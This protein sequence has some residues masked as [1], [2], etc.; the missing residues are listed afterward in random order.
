MLCPIAAFAQYP[1]A[2]GWC[3]DGAQNVITSGLTSSSTV[4]GSFPQCTVTISI[5]GGGLATIYS[6]DSGTPLANPFTANTNGQWQFFALTGA[7]DIALSGAGF[8]T[9]ITY[10]EVNIGFGGG[11][12]GGSVASVSCTGLTPL[13]T[14]A[15]ANPTTNPAISFGLSNAAGNT[16]F[17]NCSG[18][19]G[20]PSYCAITSAMLPSGPATIGGSIASPQVAFGSGANTISGSNALTW[21]G[22]ALSLTGSLL[23]PGTGSGSGSISVAAAAGT[24]CTILLPTTSPSAGQFLSSA[25]PST[26]N[27][28]SSWAT[29]ST[30]VTGCTTTG[31]VAFENGTANTLGCGSTLVL[32]TAFGQ[33]LTMT[34]ASAGFVVNSAGSTTELS[35]MGSGG[36]WAI[37][38][39]LTGIENL[40]TNGAGGGIT[41]GQFGPL[42]LGLVTTGVSGKINFTGKTSGQASISIADAAGTPCTI[43]LPTTSPSANQVLSSAA[44]SGGS[45]QTSWAASGAGSSSLSAITPATAGNTIANGNNGLQIWNWAPTS[46]QASFQIGETTAATGGTLGSQ[47]GTRF[48]SLAGSTSVPVGITSSITGS[49]TL[50]SLY[51]TP[52]WNTSGVVAGA[53][54]L[55]VTNSAS[56]AGSLLLNLQVGG[57]SEASIDKAG[58]LL[59]ASTLATGTAPTAC[60]SATGCVAMTEAAT[61]GT[62]TAAQ[63]YI[64]A[65]NAHQ[66]VTSINNGSELPIPWFSSGTITGTRCVHTIGTLGQVAET[67][68]D[69]GTGSFVFPITVSGT[70]TSGGIPYFNSTT[71]LSS[72][73]ILN[74]NILVK[75]G[76]AGGAPTNSSATDNG[77]T[78][79]IAE[80]ATATSLGTG[81]S[82]PTC[83]IGTSGALCENEGTAVTG[84]SSVD[85]LWANAAA[86][87][88]DQNSNNVELGCVVSQPAGLVTIQ[89]VTGAD[90]TNSTVTPSTVFSWTLPATAAAKNY[91]YTC[92]IMWESTGVT[93][94]GPVFGLNLSAAPTQLT[95]AAAVQNALTGVD[96]NGYLSNTTTGSQTLVTS[97]AAGVTSTNY[98]ARIWGTIE[99]SPTA[100][101]TF[102]INAASTSG[103]TATLNIRRG[104]ACKLEVVQ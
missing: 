33:Q 81:T 8:P 78:F 76:G 26:G 29:P 93:L 25:A 64:R 60:G 86:H 36:G 66:W 37:T 50:P 20:A 32:T 9:T 77:T 7:Y 31:G 21:S 72:S 73:G 92:E 22:S 30:A 46:N 2:Q 12:G 14:C 70:T 27:C 24:P 68:A 75:G 69:C 90:Y 47:F 43:L 45:C 59:A 80:A 95:G 58:N 57:A 98:W 103:T 19:T 87:C 94:V 13:Y 48:V 10:L 6:N 42:N 71:Q 28:Q 15:V 52:T 85:A 97:S 53:I 62:P 23:F 102:I 91:K 84:A 35:N 17:G 39:S 61:A 79:A 40:L 54:N 56:G 51:I 49:Q 34:G 16:I 99:G 55:N 3:E 96:V 74:T 88:V 101:A 104:S 18:V 41:T 44:P 83:T 1:N 11:G 38:S 4:Q 63:D 5:H 100:G 82:P 89:T 67:A 65:S